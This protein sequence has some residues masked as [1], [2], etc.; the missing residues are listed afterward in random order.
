MRLFK[1]LNNGA[2][3]QMAAG[4]ASVTTGQTYSY[5]LRYNLVGRFVLWRDG[6]QVL[7][8][9]DSAGLT[10]GGYLALRTDSSVVSFDDIEVSRFK[11][12]YDA[13][14]Q[15]VAM[16]E[17]ETLSFLLTD[18]LGSTAV[19]AN[20]SGGES[21]KLLYKPWGETRY[22][23]GSTPTT[24]HFTGQR[25]D[26]SIGLYYYGAR[27]YDPV[28]G[29]FAQAD[30]IVPEP[31]NPQAL[32]RY[33]YTLNNPVRYTDP[34]GHRECEDQECTS[35]V[36]PRTGRSFHPRPPAYSGPCVSVV[37][38]PTPTP[39]A[40]P[41]PF[42]Y[43]TPYA[44]PWMGP[45][46]SLATSTPTATPYPRVRMPGLIN[47]PATYWGI[48]WALNVDLPEIVAKYSDEAIRAGGRTANYASPVIGYG[49]GLAASVGPNLVDHLIA[50]ERVSSPE[51]MTDVI[52]DT[53]GWALTAFITEPG[54][55]AAGSGF[56][57][58]VGGPP[59]GMAGA[60]VG[61][62]TGGIGASI[63]WDVGAV[64]RVRPWVR[65]WFD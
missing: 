57:T 46:A 22:S 21:G 34:T 60:V 3:Q 43:A 58:A 56:G 50:G 24:Y 29:R 42:V 6:V 39:T 4:N 8:W 27:Y 38:L 61:Y 31:G 51:V 40:A 15:R 63:A 14:G 54:L 17:A 18:H 48:A 52:V 9:T 2:P 64:P 16:R 26:A 59:S 62:L 19:T 55:T 28:L 13:G 37:C 44:G 36:H 20:S 47:K 1:A 5:V 11:K 10:T 30:T 32:N 49:V 33:A 23:S 41:A 7:N 12:Y 25:E 45:A 65:S 53:S 35:W